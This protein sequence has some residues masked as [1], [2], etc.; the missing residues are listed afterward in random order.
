MIGE[1]HAAVRMLL[2]KREVVPAP[3][4]AEPPPVSG[5]IG[6]EPA[7]GQLL[8]P[9]WSHLAIGV[10][11]AW[12]YYAQTPVPDRGAAFRKGTE[13]ALSRRDWR[14]VFELAA[15]SP[16]GRSAPLYELMRR[17]DA[18]PAS[19]SACESAIDP[20]ELPVHIAAAGPA[21]ARTFERDVRAK[22]T[23]LRY[24]LRRSVRV[25]SG[26][27]DLLAVHRDAVAT[28][29]AFRFLIEAPSGEIRF[30]SRSPHSPG[31]SA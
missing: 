24:E 28:G 17:L 19:I 21:A 14:A 25:T 31:E 20:S 16:S 7:P 30:G 5:P 10:D 27:D 8:L 13:L 2:R 6:R 9:D 4:P 1:E 3:K 12:R 26:D 18:L 11:A 15:A 29:F 23:R 22:L